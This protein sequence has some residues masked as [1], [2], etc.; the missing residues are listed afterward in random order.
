M[1]KNQKII[2][3]MTLEEKASLTSG[4]NFWQTMNLSKFDIPS[5]FLADGP[6]GLRKQIASPNKIGLN[7]SVQATAFPTFSAM[8]NSWD[9]ELMQKMGSCIGEEAVDE[10]VSVVLGPGLNIKRNPLCGRN[11]EYFSEDPYLS[12]KMAAS[13][14]RGIQ[15]HGVYACAKHFACQN[16]ET[17]RMVIDS[18]VDERTLRELYLTGFEIALKEGQAKSVMT[19]YNK[20][21]GAY[22]NENYHLMTGVLRNDWGFEGMVVSNWGG[23]NDRVKGLIAGND[24]EMPSTC[25]ETNDEIVAAVKSG[26]IQEKDLDKSCD[27]IISAVK[28]TQ[29]V[30]SEHPETIIDIAGHANVALECAEKSM[31]LLKNK[32]NVLPLGKT[33]K[34]AV[35][36]DFANIKIQGNG[37]SKVNPPVKPLFLDLIKDYPINY[38]GYQPGYKRFGGNSR[39]LLN[40]A[41]RLGDQADVILVFLGLDEQHENDGLDRGKLSLPKNQSTLIYEL[42]QLNKKVVCILNCG[43]PVE[44]NFADQVY[45][46][47]HMYLPGEEG[48]RALLNILTGKVNPSGKLA[49]SYP[50]IYA[51]CPNS[52]RFANNPLYIQYREGIFVG[53]RYY[54]T[55]NVQVRYPFGFGL[56]Y[57][58]F[59][60]SDLSVSKNGV[61]FKITNTGKMAGAEIAQLYVGLPDSKIFRAKE[62]LKGFAKVYLE[63]GETKEVSIGFDDKAFRFFN[64]IN[65]DFEIEGGNYSIMVGA[66]SEDIR[67]EGTLEVK[68]IDA[69]GIYLKEQLPSYFSGNVRNVSGDEFAALIGH[70]LPSSKSVFYK[71]N[72][73]VVDIN[74][75]V[76]DLKYA[77]GWLGRFFSRSVRFAI[78][79]L[80]KVGKRQKSNELI[81]GVLNDPMRAISRMSNG[82]ISWGQIQ[83]LILVFNGHPFKGWHKFRVEKKKKKTTINRFKDRAKQP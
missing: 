47:I 44:L 32:E 64:V 28:D 31:V 18:I 14:I 70:P 12:G 69:S 39:G 81:M 33:E 1:L 30:F 72:R 17:R 63:P 27:R 76:N 36:G 5:V 6:H 60:Y 77:K 46:L 80:R 11:F 35:I 7:I 45:G 50:Y 54:E 25:G 67:L 79:F 53:Y 57:T 43:A 8:A 66:S 52:K 61:T 74:T 23:S 10:K 59:A 21:N 15:S 37:S 82:F 38:I 22:A 9:P 24:L 56:S 41:I 62:E 49:E 42:L 3:Q 73:I 78:W 75:T 34:V 20:I 29:K 4:K 13:Y 71:K 26:L 68:G 55:A 16:Q 65:N 19:A 58:S 51:D 83:G 40:K 48:A 2:D